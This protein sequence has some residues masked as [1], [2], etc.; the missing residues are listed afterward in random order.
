MVGARITFLYKN[1]KG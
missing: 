1:K